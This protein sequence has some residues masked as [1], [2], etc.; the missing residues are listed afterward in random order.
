MIIAMLEAGIGRRRPAEMLMAPVA[1]QPMI[2]RM[3]ERVRMARTLSKVIVAVS[4]DPADDAL[5]GYLTSRG[6]PVLRG[7]PE[8]A[9]TGYV[10]CVR[11]NGASQAVCLSADTPLIDPGVIDEAVRY[12]LASR[13]DLV[14][15]L[16]Y[17]QGLEVLVATDAALV[18][19]DAQA[20]GDER[21][22]PCGF[23]KDA[24]IFQHA[25]FR[26]RRDW[27]EMNWRADT[28]GGFA[29][30]REAFEALTAA[31]PAFGLEET[32]DWLDHRPDLSAQRTIQA[33]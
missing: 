19:A 22:S 17:P 2:W 18:S 28:P 4:R 33:A 15:A 6:V 1:G 9:L 3:V 21:A 23:I 14:G 24:G 30:A 5:T 29:I 13:S 27:S 11:Q 16:A 8:D 26:A 32:L 25:W 12:S 10:Q 20:E 7:Q 31:D